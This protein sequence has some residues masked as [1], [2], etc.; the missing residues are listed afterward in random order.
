MFSITNK[1]GWIVT[2]RGEPPF[3]YDPELLDRYEVMITLHLPVYIPLPDDV[4]PV[5]VNNRAAH[6]RLSRYDIHNENKEILL[7]SLAKEHNIPRDIPLSV[8]L[9]RSDPFNQSQ[10]IV[11]FKPT[12]EE[13][14][15]FE[16]PDLEEQDPYTKSTIDSI[17]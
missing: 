5:I 15:K 3:K 16:N 9:L 11:M 13:L 8:P 10:V 17:L 4:Y 1:D 6:I 2:T 12:I 14:K 7:D